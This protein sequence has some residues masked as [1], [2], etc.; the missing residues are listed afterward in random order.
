MSRKI[1]VK[2][3]LLSIFV[4]IV[5]LTNIAL[6]ADNETYYFDVIS[7]TGLNEQK[8]YETSNSNSVM[9]IFFKAF[10]VD[11]CAERITLYANE[12][13]IWQHI[14][15]PSQFNADMMN[16]LETAKVINGDYGKCA[17]L[18]DWTKYLDGQEVIY[19][20]TIPQLQ[21]PI[22]EE[23]EKLKFRPYIP[24]YHEWT[25]YKDLHKF[26][27]YN[28]GENVYKLVEALGEKENDAYIDSKG[29][30]VD[31]ETWVKDGAT[32]IKTSTDREIDAVVGDYLAG[33]KNP[34][35]KDYTIEFSD[36]DAK[37]KLIMKFEP[38]ALQP[39]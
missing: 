4:F 15:M 2:K 12:K 6:A 14:A 3:I 10:I 11:T 28:G 33:D 8:F 1:E 38:M 20:D 30:V 17:N 29:A 27:E 9:D 7:S 26:A 32:K 34:E 5:M 18:I 37:Y 16:F 24:Y 23:D 21:E 25:E 19:T 36:E 22:T 13:E 39:Y 31:F 35:L